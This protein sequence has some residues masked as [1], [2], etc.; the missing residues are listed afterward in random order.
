MEET[1]VVRDRRDRRHG[2]GGDHRP[3]ARDQLAGEAEGRGDEPC[4]KQREHEQAA[5]HAAAHDRVEERSDGWKKGAERSPAPNELHERPRA[6]VAQRIEVAQGE[7]QVARL[8]PFRHIAVAET[9][10]PDNVEH[11]RRDDDR[12]H[13]RSGGAN[14]RQ[15]SGV[16]R[17]ALAGD[18]VIDN[19]GMMRFRL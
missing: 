18:P 16:R 8:V 14:P 17:R 3:G 9:R 1:R 11:D 12:G 5:E 19:A 2:E 6:L 15:P 13:E 7:L 4:E 10:Q